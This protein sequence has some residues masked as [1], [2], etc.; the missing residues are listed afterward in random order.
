M[1][2]DY[3]STAS[4]FVAGQ[5]LS[6]TLKNFKP[7]EAVNLILNLV[8][9]LTGGKNR[10]Y[11]LRRSQAEKTEETV[12]TIPTELKQSPEQAQKKEQMITELRVVLESG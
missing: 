6:R 4:V 1:L 11:N 5:Y 2:N 9:R 10:L 7:V 3:D 8:S 12:E